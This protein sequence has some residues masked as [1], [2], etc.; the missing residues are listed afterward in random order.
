M[1]GR[2]QSIATIEM[3][4]IEDY[5]Q[6]SKFAGKLTARAELCG[7]LKQYLLRERNVPLI[8]IPPKSLKLYATGNG[9]AG[10][11][12]ML[13][14]ASFFGFET[15]VDDEADAFFCA[16]LALDVFLGKK[17]GANYVMHKP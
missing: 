6:V 16:R 2:L 11:K 12:D 3:A 1:I 9:N 7:I 14:R 4:A 15:S 13:L 5:G 8:T 10:K 17:T